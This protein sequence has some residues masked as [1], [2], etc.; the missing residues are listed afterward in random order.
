LG[1]TRKETGKPFLADGLPPFA[2]LNPTIFCSPSQHRLFSKKAIQTAIS[3]GI[4]TG[5]MISKIFP[6]TWTKHKPRR[7]EKSPITQRISRSLFPAL[8]NR[9]RTERRS[10]FQ[11]IRWFA[12][13]SEIGFFWMAP[14][15]W[16]PLCAAH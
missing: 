12:W 6:G 9:H 2:V 5:Q 1:K 15:A 8:V 16:H 13:L 10:L 14:F 4:H 7:V 3:I 11:K